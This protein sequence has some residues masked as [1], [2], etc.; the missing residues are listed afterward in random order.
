MMFGKVVLVGANMGV[1]DKEDGS[2]VIM[3]QVVDATSGQPFEVHIPVSKDARPAIADAIRG[4]GLVVP[5]PG[6]IV[7]PGQ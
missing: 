2:C 4:N 6:S 7:L 1:D 3:Y 5:A